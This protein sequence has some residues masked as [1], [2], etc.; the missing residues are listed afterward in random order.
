MI[1][2][3][4]IS[5]YVPACADALCDYITL[6]L[7]LRYSLCAA[8]NAM[9]AVH[10][11]IAFKGPRTVVEFGKVVGGEEDVGDDAAAVAVHNDGELV[12]QLI[13]AGARSLPSIRIA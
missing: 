1:F 5:I 4:F 12:M 11:A 6:L 7:A 13:K 3:H 8:R 2:V 9:C 10:Y